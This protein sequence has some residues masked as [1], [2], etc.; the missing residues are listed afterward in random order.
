MFN[1]SEQQG[2]QLQWHWK[3]GTTGD[4]DESS[5]KAKVTVSSSHTKLA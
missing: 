5:E 1:K 2:Q 4:G 3:D